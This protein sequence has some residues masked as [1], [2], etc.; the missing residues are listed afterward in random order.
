MKSFTSFTLLSCAAFAAAALLGGTARAGSVTY[1]G[2]LVTKSGTGFGTVLSVLALHQNSGEYGAIGAPNFNIGGMTTDS[3]GLAANASPSDGTQ[4]RTVSQIISAFGDPLFISHANTIGLIFQVNQDGQTTLN[5]NDFYV[6]FY[7]SANTL[8]FSLQYNSAVGPNTSALPGVGVGT[9]G[10]AFNINLDAGQYSQ[11]FGTQGSPN[12]NNYI[13]MHVTQADKI[14]DSNDGPD[15][16]YLTAA[17][18]N[19]GIGAGPGT[20]LPS[21]AWSGLALMAGVAGMGLWRKRRLATA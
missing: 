12:S 1:T 16:W 19:G 8:L 14:V 11:F 5:L 15:S 10:Y 9:S 3:N 20:P 17:Q 21:A 13:G 6:D 4:T 18:G 7:S 2:N